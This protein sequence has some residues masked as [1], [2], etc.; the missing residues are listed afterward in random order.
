MDI[1]TKYIT[2]ESKTDRNNALKIKL[3]YDLGG[4]NM[5]THAEQPRGYYISV[6]PVE[7][8]KRNGIK[9]ESIT[10]F[11]GYKELIEPCSRKSKKAE[12]TAIEKMPAYEKM[13][14]DY[15][16]NKYGYTI[17]TEAERL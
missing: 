3:F 17:S 6:V 14:I 15:I 9:M 11:T 16:C 5:F 8:S 1:I 12:Q 10:A 13:M 7:R 4:F 2:I